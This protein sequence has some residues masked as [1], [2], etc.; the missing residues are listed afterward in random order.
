MIRFL[1]RRLVWMVLTLWAVYTLSFVLMRSVPGDPLSSER[2]TDPVI[3]ENI[4]KRYH[5]DKPLHVQYMLGLA[6]AASGDLGASM[7]LKDFTVNQVIA[8]GLPVSASLG[9]IALVFA[10]S[11]GLG[12]GIVAAVWRGSPWDVL[13]R[14]LATVGIAV[15]NF[16]V[17]GVLILLLVF[18][19]PVFPA[20]GWGSIDQLFL[21]AF[22]LGGPYAA[23]IARL[24]RTGLLDT[25]NQDYIRTAHAKGLPAATVVLKHALRG[26]L[27]PV[28]SFLGPAIAGILTGSLVVEQ[29]FAIPGLGMH[30][31]QAATQRDYTLSMGL[32]LLYTALV[33]V[34]NLLVDISYA[35]IDP[36]VKLK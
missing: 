21:P 1:V 27:L 5:L 13:L 24:T 25:L 35:V 31:I 28:V 3:R 33:Y 12:A 36:R 6:D 29:I 19:W 10:L 15:P 11:L 20:A 23:Y 2:Q 9:I 16:V 4:R 8:E 18:L 30:F 7:K 32:V 26:G 22:C 17:A 14:S 34:M